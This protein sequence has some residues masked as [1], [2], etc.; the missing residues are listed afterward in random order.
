MSNFSFKIGGES[1]NC[2]TAAVTQLPSNLIGNNAVIFSH[3]QGMTGNMSDISQAATFYFLY[4]NTNRV[5]FTYLTWDE[6]QKAGIFTEKV[7][8][9]SYKSEW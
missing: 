5:W 2:V 9:L 8:C 6:S 3:L 7:R 1:W 4:K